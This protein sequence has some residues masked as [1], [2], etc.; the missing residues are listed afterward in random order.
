MQ[1]FSCNLFW[2]QAKSAL[3]QVPL[4]SSL[5]QDELTAIAEAVETKTFHRGAR[6]I[7]KGTSGNQFFIIQE[8][9]VV[10]TNIGPGVGDVTLS[11][12]PG[13]VVSIEVVMR[14]CC[15]V[16]RRWRILWGTCAAV[17]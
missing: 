12:S 14:R 7:E 3:S 8:G 1:P 5:S 9:S 10:C 16:V 6:I 11:E 2:K 13:C 17:G 4:L 15:H